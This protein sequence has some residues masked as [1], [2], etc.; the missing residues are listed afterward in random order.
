M[1]VFNK[2][3]EGWIMKRTISLI[4]ALVLCLSL[5]A[6]GHT[7][8]F[9][10]WTTVS[11]ATCTAEGSR[12]RVCE[13]GEKETEAVAAAGHSY[14]E[15]VEIAAATCTEDGQ[16]EKTC[17]RC[18]DKVTEI[19]A[20]SGHSFKAA[21]AFA[22]KTC[23]A[24]GITEGDPLAKLIA[25]G[26][27]IESEEHSFTVE[28]VSFTGSLSEKRGRTTYKHHSDFVL[29]IKLDFTNLATEAFERWHSDRVTDVTMEYKEKYRYEGEYWI[30]VDDIVPLANDTMYVIFEVP[31]NMSEDTTGSILV[32]FTIDDETYAIVVQQGDGSQSEESEPA[33]VDASGTVAVGDEVTNGATFS[34]VFKDLYYASEVKQKYGNVTHSFSS[35][36]YHLVIKLDLTNLAAEM[37]DDWNSDRFQDIVL[38]YADK[39]TY[40]GRA[41]I[42]KDEIVPLANGDVLIFFKIPENIETGSES[43]VATFTIDGSVFTVNCR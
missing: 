25:V 33:Q 42:P 24:C 22:P 18:G 43:L 26:D 20:S 19:V 14:G 1:N 23:S 3:K 13:C 32:T 21:S 5:C 39:Y 36:G 12:E 35:D 38:T 16:I 2:Q 31:K 29:A 40:E 8:A 11:E 30:P 6:C 28:S 17:T 34:F 9:G 7:H 37:L 41:W 10:E 27:V 15:A 4:L